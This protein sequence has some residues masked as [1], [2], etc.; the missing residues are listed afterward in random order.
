MSPNAV[1][2]SAAS[3]TR[4]TLHQLLVAVEKCFEMEHSG[5]KV[6]IETL[7]DVTLYGDKSTNSQIEVKRYSDK[8]TDNH[9][10]FWKTLKNWI[11]P[12]FEPS[13]YRSL[14][15]LTTQ[16]YGSTSTISNWNNESAENRLKILQ[17]IL[18]KNEDNY[19]KVQQNGTSSLPESLKLQRFV[20]SDKKR[21]KLK[22]ILNLF[23]IEAQSPD[24]PEL[25]SKIKGQ[26]LKGVLVGKQDDFLNAL[27]GFI[28]QP[29]SKNL[30]RWEISYDDFTTK[31]QELTSSYA[32]GTKEFPHVA[33][34]LT[35]DDVSK[36]KEYLFVQK[37]ADIEYHD[38]IRK[39]IEHYQI[40][41]KTIHQE[42]K[43]YSVP[44]ERTQK[45]SENIVEQFQAKHRRAQR[46]STDPI[47]DA[48]NLYDEVTGSTPQPFSGFDA[49]PIDFRNGLLHSEMDDDNKN[50]KW[51]V[52]QN[53]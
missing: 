34:S 12:G 29:K 25:Y 38:V 39:A 18:K 6:L 10:V 36:G 19:K 21:E 17:T 26:Y 46:N 27:Y 20:L 2:H 48:K 32:H 24:T 22:I 45:Y 23:F 4:G 16:E 43:S 52:D 15:L 30:S 42:F 53:E 13:Q 1:S 28:C 14:I 50:L 41:I 44:A 11:Y 9:R 8:L 5:Q 31:V 35:D 40:A 37:I 33:V 7:G 51:R 49:T 3:S 47:N